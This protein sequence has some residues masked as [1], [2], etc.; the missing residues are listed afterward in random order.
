MTI[1]R[2]NLCSGVSLS[3]IQ[4]RCARSTTV[5][6]GYQSHTADAA[7]CNSRL[8]FKQRAEWVSEW[9]SKEKGKPWKEGD[10]FRGGKR[11]ATPENET[12]NVTIGV[13][14]F[15]PFLFSALAIQS[16]FTSF[17]CWQL[18][19]L[20]NL[21]LTISL[22]LS[23]SPSSLIDLSPLQISCSFWSHKPHLS[24]LS[25]TASEIS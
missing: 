12:I 10:Y 15:S 16:D 17:Y 8:K 13:C 5:L 24:M 23:S 14:L 20:S 4:S 22:L 7:T 6:V 25:R 21:L 3:R 18:P 9:V 19:L 1:F 2:A 11:D